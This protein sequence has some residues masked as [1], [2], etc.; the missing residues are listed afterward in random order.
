LALIPRL[1]I[2][3]PRSS[4]ETN[5]NNADQP[6]TFSPIAEQILKLQSERLEIKFNQMAA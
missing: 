3:E 4:C 2:S 1:R 6:V 5:V